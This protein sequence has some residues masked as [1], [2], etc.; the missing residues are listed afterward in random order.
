[1]DNALHAPGTGAGS[2]DDGFTPVQN[3]AP[4]RVDDHDEQGRLMGRQWLREGVLHGR[5]E[6]FWPNGKPQLNANYDNGQLDGLLYLF[7][8]HGEPLQVAAYMQGRQHGP[9]RMFVHRRCVSEQT[10]VNGVAHGPAVTN[11]AA[12]QPSAKMNFV[13]GQ[14]DGPI[15]FFHEGKVVRQAVYQAGL[16]EGEAS[17]F[18]RDGGLVQVASY[19]A[20]VLEGP[21][22]RYW[23]DG[24][25]MEEV[26]YA[27]G[28]PV[29]LPL[30]LDAKGRQIDNEEAQ[31][32]LLARLEKMVRG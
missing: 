11:D 17:D 22:R 28:V 25:L 7:D 9:T 19:R 18:D 1:M 24:A 10:F 16:L 8:E 13:Q 31:L 20:N 32:G 26:V 29:G 6:R 3:L 12:G 2:A 15:T 14:V 21:L 23:P 27:Q 5:M 30:R 4:E